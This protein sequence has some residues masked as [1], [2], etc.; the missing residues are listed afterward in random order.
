MTRLL[1]TRGLDVDDVEFGTRM[2]AFWDALLDRFAGDRAAL[3]RAIRMTGAALSSDLDSD[4]VSAFFESL[5]SVPDDDLTLTSIPVRS[6]GAGDSELYT[7]DADEMRGLVEATLGSEST[8]GE[9]V[10]V[11]VLNGNGIPGIGQEVVELLDGDGFRLL[12]SGNARSLDYE[13]TLIVTYDDSQEGIAIAERARDLLG[14]G[15]VQ[16]SAQ[17]QGIVDLT[18]VVGKDFAGA[19]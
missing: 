2:L 5:A 15:E 10:R 4:E 8:T 3:G 6:I 1:Y 11:Q 17:E 18:I 13:K 16:I 14:V 12:L 9:E 19:E 7:T